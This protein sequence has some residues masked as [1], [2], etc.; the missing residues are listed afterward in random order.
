MEKVSI[1]YIRNSNLKFSVQHLNTILDSGLKSE[2]ALPHGCK[3]GSCGSCKAKLIEG[4]IKTLNGNIISSKNK[5]SSAILLCQSKAY[6]KEIVIE[7]SKSIIQKIDTEL[8]HIKI[9]PMELNLEVISNKQVTPLVSELKAFIPTKLNFRFEAGMHLDFINSKLNLVKKY[10]IC[11][12]PDNNKKPLQSIL[13]F[14]IAKHS[15]NGLSNYLSNNTFPGDI[16]NVK[17]PYNSFIYKTDYKK[18]LIA[19]AGGTGIAP[20]L[21]ILKKILEINN[22]LYVMVLLSVRSRKEILEMDSLYKLKCKYNNFSFK[23][24]LTR[25]DARFGTRFLSGRIKKVLPKIFN[26]LSQHNIFICGSDGF[27]KH[28]IDAAFSLKASKSNIFTETFI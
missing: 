8:P 9:I 12:P 14:L 11:D 18:P 2:I 28:S 13:R 26:D 1:A 25:E 23:I 4:K 27:V 21:P 22:Q 6:T 15:E 16:I 19:L 20:I 5:Q 10:S 17:G 3:S 7:Y 24:T